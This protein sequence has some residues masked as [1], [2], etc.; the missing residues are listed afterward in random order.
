M[1]DIEK[2]EIYLN[3]IEELNP[4]AKKF[5]KANKKG[6]DPILSER[7]EFIFD[8]FQ[9]LNEIVDKLKD[10]NYSVMFFSVYPNYKLWRSKI[11]RQEYIIYH[12]EYY[13]INIVALYDRLLHFVNFIY[14]LGLADQFVTLR[15]IITNKHVKKETIKILKGIDKTL[16]GIRKIQNK[17]KHKE[18]FR[19]KK[20][21][22]PSLLEFQYRHNMF[23]EYAPEFQNELK[24]DINFFYRNYL[25]S[26]KKELKENNKALGNGIK[27][28]LDNVLPIYTARKAKLID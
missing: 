16:Q 19:D 4:I 6:K 18:K 8:I 13:Y 17:I 27:I 21:Y 1:F 12:L 2:H 26:K 15:S 14:D 9:R 20:M 3:F 11:T 10:L 7:E 24:S 23:A 25:I 5:H 28:L 22:Y